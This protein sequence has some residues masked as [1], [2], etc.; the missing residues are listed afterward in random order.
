MTRK[1]APSRRPSEGLEVLV[2][3]VPAPDARRRLVLS[4]D[5]IMRAGVWQERQKK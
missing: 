2:E 5:I 3:H 4:F 1:R